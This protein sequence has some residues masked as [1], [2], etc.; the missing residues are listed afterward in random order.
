M[1]GSR[2]LFDSSAWIGML[3]G[4]NEIL[5]E[6]L[7][8]EENSFFT[9][10]VTFFEIPK[11]SILRGFSKTQIKKS[12]DFIRGNSIVMD[13]NSELC[14][15]AVQASVKHNLHAMDALIY[16][17][18]LESDAILVTMDKDFQKLPGVRIVKQ[19]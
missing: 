3:Q 15:K 9:S 1:T 2:Y 4:E 14:E 19:S 6:L 7:K 10:A 17:S 16:Q 5:R 18:A 8:E 12:L 13:V 11:K